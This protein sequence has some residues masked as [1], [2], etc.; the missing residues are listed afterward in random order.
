MT[1]RTV[2]LSSATG[3]LLMMFSSMTG[4]QLSELEFVTAGLMRPDANTRHHVSIKR[5]S[6]AQTHLIVPDVAIYETLLELSG[7]AEQLAMVP[8][9]VAGSIESVL[10]DG[11]S[12]E[13]FEPDDIPYLKKAIP[14]AFST[15]TLYLAVVEQ[16]QQALSADAANQLVQ[17]YSSSLGE[18]LRKAETNYSIL[19]NAERFS[20]WY[21]NGGVASLSKERQSALRELEQAMQATQGAVDAMIGMQVAMQVSLTPVLPDDQQRSV[22]DLLREAQIQRPGLSKHYRQSSLETLSFVFQEQSRS[23]LHEYSAQLRTEAGQQY[24]VAIND[25]LSRGLFRAAEALGQSIQTLLTGRLGQG[26]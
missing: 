7:F 26:V 5:V 10:L 15:D 16:L 20:H 25:G 9:A 18:Q 21:A 1:K 19:E 3:T 6:D 8:A 24:V 11:L 14:E 4:A 17:F 12:M 2:V 22:S 23:E 13:L